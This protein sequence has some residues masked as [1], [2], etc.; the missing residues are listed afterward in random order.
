MSQKKQKSYN[1]LLVDDEQPIIN[2]FCAWLESSEFIVDYANSAEEALGYL[3][4]NP[5]NIVISDIS[6]EGMNGIELLQRIKKDYPAIEV[7]IVTGQ[8]NV[9]M[10][11][12]ALK[13]GA[14]DFLQKPLDKAKLDMSIQR[15]VNNLSFNMQETDV[16]ES[17]RL[18]KPGAKIGNYYLGKLIGFGAQAAVYFAHDGDN[19]YKYA[20]K[21]Q[22]L[23][24]SLPEMSIVMERIRNEAAA[25]R[26]IHHHNIVRLYDSGYIAKDGTDVFYLLT[27]YVNGQSLDALIG[28]PESEFPMR[29][30]ISIMYQVALALEEIH[31]H[32]L[33]HR[34]IKPSNI[35]INDEF[36]VK[37]TDFGICKMEDS[38]LTCTKSIVGTPLYLAPEYVADGIV[39]QQLDIYSLG[40]VSYMMFLNIPPYQAAT[41]NDLIMKIINEYPVRPRNIIPNFPSKLQDIIGRMLHKKPA[42]RYKSA[43]ELINDLENL[44]L[45]DAS[46]ESWLDS[47]R[48]RIS[49]GRVWK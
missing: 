48:K 27:E 24:S 12:N 45:D 34:D 2:L 49:E 36:C 37:I 31:K 46:A 44:S 11:V 8:G 3:S 39:N 35:L 41:Y 7:I 15:A 16:T 18:I 29:S 25:L 33:T 14:C 6:M 19:D 4:A 5:C 30:K 43:R 13:N 1:I 42:K 47:V 9:E 32:G 21:V 38:T 40:I 10:A 28:K 23:F 26:K 22:Q 20:M 17:V